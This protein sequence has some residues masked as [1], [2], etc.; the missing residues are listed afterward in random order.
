LISDAPPR[1]LLRLRKEELVH[2]YNSAGLSENPEALTKQEI[3]DVIVAAR[4]D[5]APAPPSS[6]PGVSSGYSSDEGNAAGDEEN[7]VLPRY[8]VMSNGLRRRATTNYL[9]RPNEKP[10][11][12]RSLSMGN[13]LAQNSFHEGRKTAR[14]L[15]I[16][17]NGEGSVGSTTR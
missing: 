10:C 6:P 16:K 9:S 11:K 1:Q 15:D 4:D 8:E 13:L 14:I 7:N 5:F 2:L 12:G 3:V 17:K